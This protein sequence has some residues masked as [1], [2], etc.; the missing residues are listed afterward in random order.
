MKW[1]PTATDF[2]G[3][4]YPEAVVQEGPDDGWVR[5]HALES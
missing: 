2:G 1:G 4:R 5:F 3:C